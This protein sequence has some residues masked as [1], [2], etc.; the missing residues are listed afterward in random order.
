MKQQVCLDPSPLRL[1]KPHIIILSIERY[2]ALRRKSHQWKTD[3]PTCE[4]N[5][6]H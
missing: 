4:S 6:L 5:Q 1:V 2:P 3:D